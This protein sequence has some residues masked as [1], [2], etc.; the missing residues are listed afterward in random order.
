M[1]TKQVCSISKMRWLFLLYFFWTAPAF[2]DSAGSKSGV[3]AN[4]LI[5][6]SGAGSLGGVG[7]NVQLNNNMGN[8]SYTI[9]M[10]IPK[11]RGQATPS[12]SI[13][14]NSGASPGV[15]GI[16][17]GLSAGGSIERLTVRGLPT[18]TNA[19][20]FY[21]STGEL[22][23][24]PNTAY[25]RS[26]MEGGFVRYRWHQTDAND[27]RGYWTAEYPNGNI[28]YFGASSDGKEDLGS[29]V[30]GLKGTFRWE[31]NTLVDRNGNKIRYS[32]FREGSQ[33][34]LERIEWVFDKSENPLYRMDFRYEDR[35]D[36]I[37]DGKP[38]FDLVTKKRM[39]E[40]TIFSEGQRIRSYDLT[41]EDATGLSR[42]TKVV[43]YG[44]DPK[45]A[46]P[47][48]FSMKYSN[49]TASQRTLYTI[50]TPVGPSFRAGNSD[51]I[52]M[53]GDGLPDTLD[54]SSSRHRFYIND[55]TINPDL[56]M[57]SHDF[58]SGKAVDNP[59]E[60]SAKLSNPAVQ[61]LDFN[62]D[63]FTDMVD[64]TN[65]KIYI[66]RGNSKWEDQSKLLQS[67]PIDGKDVNMR[68]F[69]YNGDKAIDII[70]SDGD[71]TKY[72]VSDKQGN[73]TEVAGGK[74]IGQAIQR[75]KVRLI[76]MNGDGL[77]DAVQIFGGK[78]RYR[79]YLGYGN[80][81]DWIE[82]AVPELE[83][84]SQT[85]IDQM[86]FADMNGDG[87]SDMVTFVGTSL[88]YFVNQNGTQFTK[89]VQIQ[90][91]PNGSIPDSSTSSIRLADMNGNGSR[92]IVWIDSSGQVRYLEL[93]PQRPN[94]LTEI[95]NGI[96]QRIEVQYGS[97]VYHYLRDVAAGKPWPNKLPT[98]FVVVNRIKTWSEGDGSV[99]PSVRI[100][101][102]AYHNGFY[103]GT[104]KKFRGFERVESTFE[105]D[106]SV[107]K[108]KDEEHY[109]TGAKDTY[110][111]GKLLRR[112]VSDGAQKTYREETY[113]WKDCGTP[114]GAAP[115]LDPPVRF[116][117]LQ[118]NDLTWIEGETDSSKHR[119][120]RT[121]MD[122][123]GFGNVTE[124]R[125]LG[126]VDQEGDERYRRTLFITPADPTS[127]QASWNV[128]TIQHVEICD[129]ASGPC[130]RLE[131]FYDGEDYKG[132]EAGKLTKGNIKRIRALANK[133]KNEYIEVLGLRHDTFGNIISEKNGVGDERLYKFDEVYNRFAVEES[134]LLEGYKL[135]TTARWDYRFSVIVE[136]VTFNG[137][138]RHYTYDTFGRLASIRYP[139][140]AA[141]KPAV[142]YT[143]DLKGPLTRVITEK[144]ATEGGPFEHKD[145]RC[146]DG[147]GRAISRLTQVAADR[148]IVYGLSEYN[149]LNGLARVWEAHEQSDDV[150]RFKAPD[151]VETTQY[152]YDGMNRPIE[153]ILADGKTRRTEYAPLEVRSFDEEDTDTQS[154]HFNTPTI[155]LQDGLGREIE[156]IQTLANNKTIKTR[157]E[158]TQANVQGTPSLRKVILADGSSKE[159]VYDLVGR[160]LKLVDPDR[161]TQTYAY[162]AAGRV[163]SYVDARSKEI[164]YTYDAA[165]RILQREVVGEP[166]LLT[167]F[168]YDK[169]EQGLATATNVLGEMVAVK[170]KLD[171][172]YFSYDTR[173]KIQLMRRVVMGRPFDFGSTFDNLERHLS[174]TLPHGE[175]IRYERDLTGR[176]RAVSG[177]IESI[178]Y[179]PEGTFQ[180]WK[181]SNGIETR[182]LYDARK[183]YKGIE[184]GNGK[185]FSLQ[186]SLDNHGNIL[187]WNQMHGDKNYNHQYTYD[188]MYRLQKASLENSKEVLDYTYDDINN[189]TNKRSSLGAQSPAHL[190]DYA[191][192]PQRVCT[193]AA[194]GNLKFSYN[195]AGYTLKRGE[196]SLEWDAYGQIS[197]V[198]QGEKTLARY[199]YG[200]QSSPILAKEG[201]LHI[202]QI[203]PNYE[204]RDGL[205]VSYTRL[206]QHRVI[207]SRTTKG[208]HLFFDDV[209]PAKGTDALTAEPDGIISV[210]DA[211]L[212]HAG[213]KGLKKIALQDRP[214]DV[215]LTEDMLQA[216]LQQLM[217]EESDNMHVYHVDHQGSTRAVTNQKGDVI[218]RSHFYPYGL[219]SVQEGVQAAY[220]Y[221]GAA[222]SANTG[223]QRFMLRPLDP[224]TGRWLRPDPAFAQIQSTSDEFNG[225]GM[226]MN[227][228]IRNRERAWLG[229]SKS[230]S[231]WSCG[232]G[233]KN[234]WNEIKRGRR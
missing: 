21:G 155:S 171:A 224:K 212:Y 68:F 161:S 231:L 5:L 205:V 34:Y 30:Y 59:S 33:L 183:R 1:M 220:G 113:A 228:P 86:Q 108:R 153:V 102:I 4:V 164:R 157:F 170:S 204:I 147:Q 112:I 56:S 74:G 142:R 12:V 185:V 67:F 42:L 88:V 80:W 207:A 187:Q 55:V 162:D 197:A 27:Q 37:S 225:F 208:L 121:E 188:A 7:E 110:F 180:S 143:Y 175:T 190:G 150:C 169:P 148:Y 63:G 77:M 52:D 166:D 186:Y 201:D 78:L 215:D 156:Q 158:Y 32:Y 223:Y 90:Q 184:V 123:D 81:S 116:I 91:L 57:K 174:Q 8:M 232:H 214:S 10:E 19:D 159:H 84:L 40:I 89:G 230:W 47:I 25:Y 44:V 99:Q 31:L 124:H 200:A 149:S 168:S 160:L 192:T 109:D 24:I 35:T 165:G 234:M 136:G 36:P 38:G 195:E 178:T 138:S 75:D 131:Y 83:N 151:N 210:A 93:F 126:R 125:Q 17:W 65:K 132:L 103:D 172:T 127:E 61:M 48:Q 209:A 11:G 176:L 213:R 134:L 203:T 87:L 23:K 76:D 3:S 145:I 194:A 22:V 219:P 82:V 49:A 51:F 139:G 107:G 135:S 58:P 154:P 196:Q 216:S 122:Y 117:C 181:A 202:V 199:W 137:Q 133:E 92:D 130:S 26:R 173:G 100:Q 198:K 111:A 2:A 6:P 129:K 18:Y 217:H 144:R 43:R 20:P 64:A 29:Q 177:L 226:V 69:D 41:F 50:P 229:L 66:N 54:T 79:K 167:T 72:W 189:I 141:D 15:V 233:P 45:E 222:Y 120:I 106:T 39:K 13:S 28:G 163:T 119:T 85:Q 152:K 206:N 104:E 218:G 62:G 71:T 73:W 46:Y 70:S 96:G 140:N 221:M 97:S 94:L 211:W 60:T 146:Y 115:N 53:N 105:G 128:R 14:Y 16:G 193:L 227:N 98:P 114:A 101:E 118:S 95:S 182:F 179:N 9:R 191:Y